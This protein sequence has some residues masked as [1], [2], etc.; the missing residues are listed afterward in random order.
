[1]QSLHSTPLSPMQQTFALTVDMK[2]TQLEI[3]ASHTMLTEL[4]E[5]LNCMSSIKRAMSTLQRAIY[6]LCAP[7]WRHKCT[8]TN[9]EAHQHPVRETQ[10]LTPL[11]AAVLLKHR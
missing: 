9:V 10:M 2:A 8:R 3:A 5:I 11:M 6:R 4:N 7:Q 1:M